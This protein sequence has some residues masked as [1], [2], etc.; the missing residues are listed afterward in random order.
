M[1]ILHIVMAVQMDVE[2]SFCAVAI[3]CETP[4]SLVV[5]PFPYPGI[6]QGGPLGRRLRPEAAHADPEVPW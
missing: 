1:L 3:S 2:V 5:N 6:P 4:L